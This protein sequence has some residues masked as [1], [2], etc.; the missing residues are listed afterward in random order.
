MVALS[1][2]LRKRW[3]IL[4][5][6]SSLGKSNL[7]KLP[8]N[9]A[10]GKAMTPNKNQHPPREQQGFPRVW[11]CVS[12]ADGY[13]SYEE[14][15]ERPVIINECEIT[16]FVPTALLAE[17]VREAVELLRAASWHLQHP[18]SSSGIDK[19]GLCTRIEDYLKSARTEGGK[20]GGE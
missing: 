1:R 15:V 17:A 11:K 8:Q 12:K 14:C 20:G 9:E 16:E 19:L 3:Q 5:A 4:A 7:Q 6:D 18:F 2:A 13:T 10:E